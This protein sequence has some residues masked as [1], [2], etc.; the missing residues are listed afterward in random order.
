MSADAI[1][2]ALDRVNGVLAA[3]AGGVRLEDVSEDGAV[4]LR[5]TGMCTGCM[6]KPLTMARIVAPALGEIAG[7]RRVEAPGTRISEAAQQRLAAVA[8]ARSLA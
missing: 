6:L 2:D 1:A 8:G 3:H 5:F 7:V 4:R